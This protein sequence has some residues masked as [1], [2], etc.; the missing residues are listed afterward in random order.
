MA[1]DTTVG[2]ENSNSYV[3]VSEALTFFNNHYITSK[4]TAW[5]ALTAPQR[6]S[7]L[8]RACQQLETLKVL[9]DELSSGRI[10]VELTIEFGWDLSIHRAEEHQRLQFPRN[11]DIDSSNNIFIPQE[12]KDSQCEQA[13]YLLAFDDTALITGT[14]GILEEAVTAG[15]VKSYTKYAGSAGNAP[16]YLSPMVIELM[17]PFLRTSGRVRRA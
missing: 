3:T 6:E 4:R 10:P 17:R 5:L 7:V 12:V 9:D 2:G 1:L 13:V 8:K 11:L 14:Q 16:T 15:A